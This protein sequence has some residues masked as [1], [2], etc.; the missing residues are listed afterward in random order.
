[1][2]EPF[3]CFRLFFANFAFRLC[4]SEEVMPLSVL[5]SCC[6]ACSTGR[7]QNAFSVFCVSSVFFVLFSLDTFN[8]NLNRPFVY[9]LEFTAATS[10]SVVRILNRNNCKGDFCPICGGSDVL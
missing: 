8:V 5:L 9:L 7:L 1:M 2:G 6:S 4:A 3:F 10:L